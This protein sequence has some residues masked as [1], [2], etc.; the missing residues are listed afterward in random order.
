MES[1]EVGIFADYLFNFKEM[2]IQDKR[3]WWEGMR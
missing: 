3:N 1:D 2:L